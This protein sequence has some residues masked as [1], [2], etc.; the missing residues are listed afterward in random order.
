M[1][2]YCDWAARFQQAVGETPTKPTIGR[3]TLRERTQA[4]AKA[5][6]CHDVLENKGG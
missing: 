3:R 6:A 5:L 1:L 4:V 2:G